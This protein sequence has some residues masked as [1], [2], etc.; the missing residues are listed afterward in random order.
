MTRNDKSDGCFAAIVILVIGIP[1][2]A[3]LYAWAAMLNWNWF[4]TTLG[5]PRIGFFQAYGLSLVV[6]SFTAHS[7][8]RDKKDDRSVSEVAI[9]MFAYISLRFALFAGLGWAVHSIM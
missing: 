1:L 6:S 8:S 5:A 9:D 7:S 3:V 2:A 4:V